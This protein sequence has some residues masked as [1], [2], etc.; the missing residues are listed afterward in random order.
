MKIIVIEPN[1]KSCT[2]H[3]YTTLKEMVLEKESILKSFPLCEEIHFVCHKEGT[4]ELL[5]EIPGLEC[6]AT[7]TCFETEEWEEVVDYIRSIVAKYNLGAEDLIVFTTAHLNEINAA[8][9]CSK[10]NECPKF[11]L[12]VHQFY[13]P[14]PDSSQIYDIKVKEYFRELFRNAF[15]G[16]DW[17]RIQIATTGVV[18]FNNLLSDMAT[19][20]LPML[21]LILAQSCAKSIEKH[22]IQNGVSFKLGFLG[23]GRKEKGLLEILKNAKQ[24]VNRF[25]NTGLLINVQNPRY[26]SSE[27]LGELYNLVETMKTTTNIEIL[28]GSLNAKRH[29]N[30]LNTLDAVILP[31]DPED[32]QIR[33]SAIVCECG[34]LGV[35]IITTQGSSM[36]DWVEEG[37]LSGVVYQ[38]G[39]NNLEYG[40]KLVEAIGILEKNYDDFYNVAQENR[41]LYA[42]ESSVGNY[43]SEIYKFYKTEYV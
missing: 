17:S 31:Y 5:K 35:P 42:K 10:Q 28:E 34:L 32:Y 21:P 18:K 38:G 37:K 6:Y 11:I 7:K 41:S 8:K 2:G 26:F 43:F 3:P 9:Y 16:I 27:E 20:K 19:R 1:L 39:I 33:L 15:E 14:L 40:K 13:R 4:Q 30:T 22:H 24:I 29:F 12:Q 25:P 23:D 36:G